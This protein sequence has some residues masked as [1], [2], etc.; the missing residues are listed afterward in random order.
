VEFAALEQHK[1][2]AFALRMDVSKPAAIRWE[3]KPLEKQFMRLNLL[4]KLVLRAV[5][6]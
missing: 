6:Q 5:V 1:D 2:G 4:V 3:F